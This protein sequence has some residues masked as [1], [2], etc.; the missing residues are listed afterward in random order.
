M[1]H[2]RSS[3]EAIVAEFE[4]DASYDLNRHRET[5]I[6]VIDELDKGKIRVAEYDQTSDSWRV[7][8]WVKQAILFFFR[9]QPMTESRIGEMHFWDKIPLK[10]NF[11]ELGV[12]VVPPAAARS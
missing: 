11:K 2:L 1:L 12:R 9:I 6:E 8:A 7:N 10:K 5:I 4:K 3:I